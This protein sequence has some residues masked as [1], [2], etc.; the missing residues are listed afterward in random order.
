ML[1]IS[2]TACFVIMFFFFFPDAD[3]I[4]HLGVK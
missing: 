2:V 4:I 1:V 3:R